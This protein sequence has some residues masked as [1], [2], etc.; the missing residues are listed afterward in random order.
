MV[1]I[2]FINGSYGVIKTFRQIKFSFDY[3]IGLYLTGQATGES[4]NFKG[5]LLRHYGSYQGF[6]E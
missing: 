2:Q 4:I 1:D 6:N 3:M 5:I